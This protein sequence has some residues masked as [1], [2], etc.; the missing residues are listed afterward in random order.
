MR[1]FKS[2]ED[3]EHAG[4]SPPVYDAVHAVVKNLVD[5]YADYGGYVADDHGY[6]VLIEEGDTD[7]DVEKEVGYNLRKA[8]F[9]GGYLENGC[10]QTCT[11]HNNEYGI[12]WIVP[13]A[14]WLE[15]EIRAKLV[16]ECDGEVP[17]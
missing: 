14:P 15:P 17:R 16:E 2:L 1:V 3:V 8:L 11:L 12:S 5:A 13:D 6:T 9:E 4:L 7:A 10:F